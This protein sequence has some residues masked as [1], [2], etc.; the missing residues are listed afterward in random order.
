MRPGKRL[1]AYVQ[2]PQNEKHEYRSP[3]MLCDEIGY[4]PFPWTLS[5]ISMSS[6]PGIRQKL[7]LYSKNV[8]E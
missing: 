5:Y 3:E 2:P 7:A 1:A 8:A 6:I 4:Q